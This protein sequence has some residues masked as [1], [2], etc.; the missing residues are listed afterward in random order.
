MHPHRGS[1]ARHRE[2]S[3]RRNQSRIQGAQ[4]PRSPSATPRVAARGAELPTIDELNERA[5]NAQEHS[6]HHRSRRTYD[7]GQRHWIHFENLYGLDK[8][9]DTP[10]A[11]D[12]QLGLFVTNLITVKNIKPATANQY[13]SHVIKTWIEDRKITHGE[14]VRTPYLAG[15]INGFL[16]MDRAEK[17]MRNAVRIPMTY[18]I[19][20][21]AIAAID[22]QYQFIEEQRIAL[23]AASMKGGL[24][25]RHWPGTYHCGGV[26]KH[27]LTHMK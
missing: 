12:I 22:R 6:L 18:P 27:I 13:L 17:P 19:L 5:R 9:G 7:T 15:I 3:R 4:R 2:H 23:R 24:T 8:I 25:N 20:L 16:R 14:E 11:L 26:I 1:R 10:I 21:V